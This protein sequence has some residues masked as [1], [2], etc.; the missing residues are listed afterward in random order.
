MVKKTYIILENI[1]HHKHT[2][3]RNM[4]MKVT[5]GKFPVRNWKKGNIH[6]MAAKHLTNHV[7]QGCGKQNV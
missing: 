7:L 1:S 4:D 6:N 3:G 5:T 2:V